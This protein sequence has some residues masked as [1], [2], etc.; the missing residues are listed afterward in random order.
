M[1][2]RTQACQLAPYAVYLMSRET[3]ITDAMVDLLIETVH[4]NLEAHVAAFRPDKPSDLTQAVFPIG[5]T[6]RQKFGRS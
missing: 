5:S 4:R 2:R 6:I 3:A 1:R